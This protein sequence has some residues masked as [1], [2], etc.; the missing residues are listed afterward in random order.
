M[1]KFKEIGSC[2]CQQ[3]SSLLAIL[4]EFESQGLE[5]FYVWHLE[6]RQELFEGEQRA[7]NGLEDQIQ[8]NTVLSFKRVLFK[9]RRMG[10]I[11][12][13]HKQDLAQYSPEAKS[14]IASAGCCDNSRGCM[15]NVWNMAGPESCRCCSHCYHPWNHI[16]TQV[17]IESQILE[18]VIGHLESQ[19]A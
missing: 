7:Q 13:N 3:T 11:D 19:N 5:N 16:I 10:E 4:S 12:T 14:I 1:F 6:P 15:S 9:L 8:E 2:N 17:L 18:R